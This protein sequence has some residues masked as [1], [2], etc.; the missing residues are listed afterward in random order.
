ML[1]AGHHFASYIER[2]STDE[3]VALADEVDRRT[4]RDRMKAVADR[5][6]TRNQADPI[7]DEEIDKMVDDVRSGTPLYERYW[8][9]RRS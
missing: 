6:R 8:T 2:L 4:W 1:F 5:I 3:R 9:R 7:S